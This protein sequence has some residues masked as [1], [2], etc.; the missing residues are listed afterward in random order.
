MVSRVIAE[1]LGQAS[2]DELCSV[3]RG[4]HDG[5]ARSAAKGFRSIHFEGNV[6]QL[7]I[8]LDPECN[9]RPWLQVAKF[10]VEFFDRGDGATVNAVDH[11]ADQQFLMPPC[12]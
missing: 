6:L 10:A 1:A 8:A 12:G 7:V 4:G 9:G 2:E 3:I 5:L 11:V